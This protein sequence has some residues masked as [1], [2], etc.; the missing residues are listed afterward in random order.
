MLLLRRQ[1]DFPFGI[2]IVSFSFFFFNNLIYSFQTYLK[3]LQYVNDILR[4]ITEKENAKND[5]RSLQSPH[6][7]LQT[8]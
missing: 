5:E 8:G 3:I 6:L 1:Y 7:F 4:D 2:N